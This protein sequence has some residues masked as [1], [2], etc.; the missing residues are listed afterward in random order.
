MEDEDVTIEVQHDGDPVCK[1]LHVLLRKPGDGKLYV[2]LTADVLK[3]LRSAVLHQ[4]NGGDMPHAQDDIEQ[5]RTSRASIS[6]GDRAIRVR[7]TDSGGKAKNKFMRITGGDVAAAVRN[8]EDYIA[9]ARYGGDDTG[10]GAVEPENDNDAEEHDAH[11]GAQ[12][13]EAAEQ[14]ACGSDKSSGGAQSCDSERGDGNGVDQ[15]MGSD[16]S[17]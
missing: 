8:A 1:E 10:D 5:Q 4:R 11:G 6:H 12:P 3:Y 9:N 16:Q 13:D 15:P 14:D 17:P 7:L 2:E